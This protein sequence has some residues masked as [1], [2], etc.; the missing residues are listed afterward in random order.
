MEI[1]SEASFSTTTMGEE[2]E[3]G[4]GRKAGLLSP[5]PPIM[6][7]RV[8]EWAHMLYEQQEEKEDRAQGG[9]TEVL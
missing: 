5:P 7:F 4:K 3:E 9:S 6:A 2:G 8:R 1:K